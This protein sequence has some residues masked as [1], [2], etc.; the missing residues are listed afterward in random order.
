MFPHVFF[1]NPTPE[2]SDMIE[3]TP[4]NTFPLDYLRIG[5]ENGMKNDLLAM[6]KDLFAERAEFWR[7]LKVHHPAV[8][9]PKMLI[10]G[11]L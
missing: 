4:A 2:D 9:D 1:S 11:E 7:N 10:K 8:G 3:W 6:E 5:N